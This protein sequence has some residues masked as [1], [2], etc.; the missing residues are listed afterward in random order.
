M[1][2]E[3]REVE[4]YNNTGGDPSAAKKFL[5][6]IARN[7]TFEFNGATRPKSL[8]LDVVIYKDNIGLNTATGQL[9]SIDLD[10]YFEKIDAGS[11]AMQ[12]L[13]QY[14]IGKIQIDYR[15]DD[16]PVQPS[17]KAFACSF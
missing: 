8:L 1:I 14:G 15:T 10:A 9:L 11:S 13:K 7:L 12:L 4:P 17:V 2:V 3:F 5:S 6:R 16:N